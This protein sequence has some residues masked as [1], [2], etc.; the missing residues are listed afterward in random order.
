MIIVAYR[1]AMNGTTDINNDYSS[2]PTGNPIKI[3]ALVE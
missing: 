3:T 1:L 2:L